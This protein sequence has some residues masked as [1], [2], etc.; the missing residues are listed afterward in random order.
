MEDVEGSPKQRKMVWFLGSPIALISEEIPVF[1]IVPRD[2]VFIK[3]MGNLEEVK[4]RGGVVVAIA[5]EGDDTV[6]AKADHTLFLP[7]LDP[8]L[9]P[10]AATVYLQLFAYHVACLLG[11]N[12]D[13]PRNLAKSVTV[14]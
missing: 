3:S 14:E 9:Y 11:R 8:L 5:T 4:S 1:F 7:P 13:R 10:V 6:Q 12:V 2:D